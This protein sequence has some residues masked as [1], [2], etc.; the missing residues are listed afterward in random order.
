MLCVSRSAGLTLP[1]RGTK[2][3]YYENG[4]VKDVKPAVSVKF[5]HAANV[6]EYA[7]AALAA[8]PDFWKG[9]GE[10][11]DPYSLC[12][13]FDTRLAAEREGWDDETLAEVEAALARVSGG[14]FIIA[15]KPPV[16]KPWPNYDRVRGEDDAETAYLLTRKIAEDGFDPRAVREYE[17]EN[18]RRPLV[19]EALDVLVAEAEADIVGVIQA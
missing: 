2:T 16:A 3:S 15:E 1:I 14:S 8:M 5:E 10:D 12:G 7:K 6:P 4:V 9:V 13:I 18:A 19:L 17:R 11:E